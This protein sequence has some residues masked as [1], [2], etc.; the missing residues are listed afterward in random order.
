M[1]ARL[2]SG[3]FAEINLRCSTNSF[4]THYLVS[5]KSNRMCCLSLRARQS[6]R[7]FIIYQHLISGPH[8]YPSKPHMQGYTNDNKYKLSRLSFK[9]MFVRESEGLSWPLAKDWS[10]SSVGGTFVLNSSI[11]SIR[12]SINSLG[13]I[14]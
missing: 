14:S 8:G 4:D 11:A 3:M 12:A 2:I 13:M 10:C 9:W 1:E 5:F 6:I 7:L